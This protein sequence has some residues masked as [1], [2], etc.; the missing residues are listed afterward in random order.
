MR[1]RRLRLE[2][3]QAPVIGRAVVL[4]AVQLVA[5]RAEGAS[6]SVRELRKRGRRLL[7]RV[8]QLFRQSLQ[9]RVS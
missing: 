1:R 8:D 4:K 6:R 7:A 9:T 5:R 3:L 2:D